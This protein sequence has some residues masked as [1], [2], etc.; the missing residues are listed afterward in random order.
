LNGFLIAVAVFLTILL[1][2]TAGIGLSY[3]AASGL[4]RALALRPKKQNAALTAA[5]V[6]SSGD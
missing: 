4:V 3:L 1:A 5:E 2:L 6:G